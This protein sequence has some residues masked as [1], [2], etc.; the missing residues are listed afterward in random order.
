MKFKKKTMRGG[1]WSK[2]IETAVVPFALV[3]LR[4]T[5]KSK[6]KRKNKKKYDYRKRLNSP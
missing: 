6:T 5:M 4:N 2:V 1:V 3:G